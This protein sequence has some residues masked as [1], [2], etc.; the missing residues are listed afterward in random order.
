MREGASTSDKLTVVK[1]AVGNHEAKF[2]KY[3]SDF[4]GMMQK[5][6]QIQYNPSGTALD[7]Q[8]RRIAENLAALSNEIDVTILSMAN[9]GKEWLDLLYQTQKQTVQVSLRLSTSFEE[10]NTLYLLAIRNQLAMEDMGKLDVLI[11]RNTAELAL[12]CGDKHTFS[13]LIH[14]YQH[15][16]QGIYQKLLDFSGVTVLVSSSAELSQPSLMQPVIVDPTK[17]LTDSVT[18]QTP[19]HAIFYLGE[20]IKGIK[21]H[22]ENILRAM[23]SAFDSQA[24]LLFTHNK[25]ETERT[26]RE[27]EAGAMDQDNVGSET[28][29]ARD[30]EESVQQEQDRRVTRYSGVGVAPGREKGAEDDG[31]V[32]E[33]E[34]IKQLKV[35]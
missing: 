12:R 7:E 24:W 31:E 32:E 25:L 21:L 6:Y 19:Q 27:T 13:A 15:H 3:R 26:Q 20:V 28:S 1:S 14:Q 5:Y 22:P 33:T 10:V 30:D 9:P 11:V 17:D 35:F 18:F 2:N 16:F 34:D 8:I 29:V 23:C 4:N